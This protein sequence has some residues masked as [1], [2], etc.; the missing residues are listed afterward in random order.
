MRFP[1]LRSRGFSLPVGPGERVLA[2]APVAGTDDVVG[3][4]RDALYLP[5]RIPW[6]QVA[7]ADWDQEE[8][9]LTVVEVAAFGEPSPTHRL[10]LEHSSRFLQLVR[11]RVTA[12][13]V[14]QRHVAI[15]GRL[16]V[17]ILARRAP[18]RPGPLTW[19]VE[20]DAGLDPEDPRVATVVGAALE[21]A[22]GDV[23]E[24]AGLDF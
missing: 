24:G 17:R 14:L 3:G 22:R 11:E 6:E 8:S 18:G 5:Q 10:Q 20:Y 4:T 19:F 7:S 23:G 15:R 16:G 2:T 1:S 13:I 12:S 21:A 9:V